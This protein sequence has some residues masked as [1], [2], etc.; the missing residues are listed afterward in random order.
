MA[1]LLKFVTIILLFVTLS[2]IYL[3]Q[4]TLNKIFLTL[5]I[6]F[7]TCFYHF[8]MRLIVGLIFSVTM[9]NRVDYHKHWFE[10]HQFEKR[11]YQKLKVK[12]WKDKMPTY[13]VDQFDMKKHSLD[14][15]AQSMTQAELVHEVIIIFSFVPIIAGYWFGSY[16]VFIITSIMAALFDFIFVMMQRYN[17]DRI[18]KIMMLRH[19]KMV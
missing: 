9:Q 10:I 17:R 14:E 2:F 8:I 6:T 18:I 4:T 7:G 3:Y 11:L 16:P 5:A 1:K 15:I 19:K 13:N 12:K